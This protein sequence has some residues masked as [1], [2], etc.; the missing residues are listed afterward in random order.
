[1]NR[2][3]TDT[4]AERAQP[5]AEWIAQVRARFPVEKA[6]DEVFTRKLKNRAQASRQEMDF[7]RLQK[8]LEKFLRDQT[9]Q[10]DLEVQDLRRLPGGASKEQ[11][12]FALN[13]RNSNGER[14]NLP[15]MLRM[16]PRESIVETHRLRECQ[17]LR[18]A[19]GEVP[20]PPVLWIDPE[21]KH[22]GQP[23]LIAGFL[24]GTVQPPQPD[25]DERM[26]GV[27][28]YFNPE[29]RSALADQFV[30]ILADI[31]AIDWQTKDLST[32]DVPPAN[33]IRAAQTSLGLWERAWYEDTLSAHPVMARAALWLRENMPIV[34]RPV[35]VHGDYRSGNFM[36]DKD[37]KINAIFDWELAYLG[38]YH[39]DLAWA[40]LPIF[41]GPD[42]SGEVL[43]SS[44]MPTQEFLQKY[45][46]LSGN[47][48]DH[49][50]FRYYQIFSFYKISVIAAATS[51][52]VAY[53]QK[54]HLDAM[55]NYSG[56]IGYVGL[57]QLN[58]LLNTVS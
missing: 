43:A 58:R 46:Q 10:P 50:K 34:E 27:G 41:G 35:L 36:Y 32:F 3:Y 24:E 7:T 55:M 29:L 13:W 53:S 26:S 40:S 48:V 19:W 45:E 6:I 8:P 12:T 15:L 38:D 17:V 16:D 33:S 56:G 21:G 2:Y 37:L 9:A 47:R 44:L 54:T 28:L 39:D 30:K 5:S 57:S 52:R 4:L 25:N 14:E 11:F 23:A 49:D 42:E 1:M 20:V 51:I 22:L 18:A 31:H